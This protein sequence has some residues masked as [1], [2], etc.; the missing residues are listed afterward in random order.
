V[1]CSLEFSYAHQDEADIDQHI[2]TKTHQ[3]KALSLGQQ[4]TLTF[5]PQNVQL[6]V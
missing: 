3:N 4:P 6:T 2:L 5:V 1:A